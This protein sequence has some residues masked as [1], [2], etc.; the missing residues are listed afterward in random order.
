MFSI[1]IPLYNKAGYVAKAVNSVLNQ[2]F[3]EFELIVVND[4]SID[5][6]LATVSAFTDNRI[7]IITQ[8]NAGVSTARNNGV[9]NAKYDYVAFLDADDWWDISFLQEI[10]V[11]I[12]KYPDAGLYAS[13]YK[14]IIKRKEICKIKIPNFEDGY[15]NYFD[16]FLLNKGT[17][18][19]SSS[20]CIK[21]QCFLQENGFKDYLK[22][23]EDTELW[24]RMACKYK[25]AYINKYLSFYN[26]DVENQAV[27]KIF[28]KE[29]CY[30]FHL[31]ELELYAKKNSNLKII[32][33]I[34]VL[35]DLKLYYLNSL[36][37]KEIFEILGKVDKANFSV[38]YRLFYYSPQMFVKILYACY[39]KFQ[40]TYLL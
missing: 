37:N 34:L 39:R 12:R 40:K 4:G 29:N 33:D 32:F 17:P 1:I 31:E 18:F 20:V 6:S 24:L 16:L 10:N 36:Y 28:P 2:T 27:R 3:S 19:N 21:K 15:I 30:I 22:G 13:N 14:Q 8:A 26:L 5:N 23:G 38:L 35:R 9:K 25:F 11:L 7:R